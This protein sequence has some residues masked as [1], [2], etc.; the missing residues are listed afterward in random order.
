MLHPLF[1][2]LIRK[3]ELVVEHLAG[4]AA[5]AHE[6]VNS[7]GTELALKAAA[8]GVAV[9]MGSVF[10]TLSG[11]AVMLG[12]V[13]TFHWALVAVPGIALLI[14]VGAVAYARKPMS[15][16]RFDDFKAQLDAD[17][18]ALRTAGEHR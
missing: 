12:F 10:I 6:E 17:V 16:K 1:T 2:I 14:A 18:V 8:W 7:F 5:L 3:P 11:A 15:G 13:N 9:V 4:Y